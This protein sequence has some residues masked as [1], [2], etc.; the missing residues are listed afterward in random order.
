MNKRTLVAIERIIT[1]INELSII[2]K[3]KS[4]EYFYDSFEMNIL[5]DIL[6]EIELNLD[7]IS[8]KIKEK[9]KNIDWDIIKKEKHYDEVFEESLNLG[10]A[11][12]LASATLKDNLLNKLIL[13]LEDELP[14]YYKELIKGRVRR[15]NADKK[16][17][18]IKRLVMY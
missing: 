15:F 14:S 7:K 6:Q 17:I 16:Q 4:V 10:K 13:L 3:N 1:C 18:I 11:W 12:I 8:I 5:L 9:Y 2:T